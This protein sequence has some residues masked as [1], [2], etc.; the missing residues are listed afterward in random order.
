MTLEVVC[1]SMGGHGG[2]LESWQQHAA[3]KH[4][5]TVDITSSGEHAGFLSKCQKGYEQS[6][7]DVIGYLHAD[8]TIHEKGWD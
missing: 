6:V 7:A 5:Y 1:P 8:L 4:T 3:H 2:A